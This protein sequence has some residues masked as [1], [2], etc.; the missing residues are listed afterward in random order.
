M[1]HADHQGCGGPP[2]FRLSVDEKQLSIFRYHDMAD[3]WTDTHCKTI[4][5]QCVFC[6]RHLFRTSFPRFPP[7]PQN[8]GFD[9]SGGAME[10]YAAFTLLRSPSTRRNLDFDGR[11]GGAAPYRS[12][13]AFPPH[14]AK[15]H[16][17][18]KR[19]GNEVSKLSRLRGSG[20]YA[21]CRD[22]VSGQPPPGTH[23]PWPER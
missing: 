7:L 22:D 18:A 20:R 9:G 23:G 5:L 21:V 12:L 8:A 13:S 6:F 16:L 10:R 3:F 11:G 1:R 2:S 19:S 17:F 14:L 15:S 4:V